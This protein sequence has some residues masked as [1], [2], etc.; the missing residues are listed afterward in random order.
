MQQRQLAACTLHGHG[1]TF[2][3]GVRDF[4]HAI[5]LFD[6]RRDDGADRERHGGQHLDHQ[7]RQDGE[8]H[9]HSRLPI[10]FARRLLLAHLR[11]RFTGDQ[12]GG[13]PDHRGDGDDQAVPG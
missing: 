5:H 10:L 2:P 9:L 8:L 12:R 11:Y 1:G 7:Q 4:F 3:V 13:G 6:I